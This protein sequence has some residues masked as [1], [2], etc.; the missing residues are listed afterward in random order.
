[1][2]YQGTAT[3]I[4]SRF[5]YPIIYSL[6]SEDTTFALSKKSERRI[7]GFVLIQ[8]EHPKFVI[9]EITKDNPFTSKNQIIVNNL[10]AFTYINSKFI[11][12]EKHIKQQIRTLYQ[13]IIYQK[14]QLEQQVI[15]N[16][17][18]WHISIRTYSL[19][20]KRLH[21]HD[22]QRNSTVTSGWLCV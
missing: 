18:H 6:T 10:D 13:N 19:F 9:V 22:R 17:I 2:L 4:N 21:R 16:A 20:D 3:R 8:T 15:R 1:M 5:R 14:Y 11:Y 12:V 7:C